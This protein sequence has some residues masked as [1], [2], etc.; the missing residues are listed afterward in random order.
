LYS[1]VPN[2]DNSK[3]EVTIVKRDELL[4]F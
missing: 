4:N 3:A 2:T 1:Q